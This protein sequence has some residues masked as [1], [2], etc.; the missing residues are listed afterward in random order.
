MGLRCILAPEV[1]SIREKRIQQ[2][3]ASILPGDKG[4]DALQFLLCLTFAFVQSCVNGTLRPLEV[5][6][7][8]M[9]YGPNGYHNDAVGYTN[10]G[11]IFDFLE[12]GEDW[13]CTWF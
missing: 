2:G 4:P 12:D 13:E 7:T 3:L 10:I 9:A 11:Q 6:L 5:Y 1:E 8:K